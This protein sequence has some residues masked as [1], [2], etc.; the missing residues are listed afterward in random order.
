MFSRKPKLP[1]YTGKTIDMTKTYWGHNIMSVYRKEDEKQPTYTGLIIVSP[2]PNVG[3]YIKWQ[4]TYGFAYGLVTEVEWLRDPHDMY[5]FKCV[6][7]DREE[8]NV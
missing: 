7:V 2:G 5:K 3:D 4:T 8:T 1:A 6:V